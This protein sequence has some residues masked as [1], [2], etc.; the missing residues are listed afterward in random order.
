MPDIGY[1]STLV[2]RL[3]V[4]PGLIIVRVAPD[5]LP[6]RFEAGQYTV[7]GLKRSAPAVVEAGAAAEGSRLSAEGPAGGDEA[8]SAEGGPG[9]A[10]ADQDPG[11]LIRRAYSIASSSKENE[12]LEFYLTLVPSGELTPRLFALETGDRLFLGPKATGLFTLAR[13]PEGF[14][15]V[16]VA[17]GTGLAPHMSILRTEL[18]GGTARRY[19]VLH[20]ARTS[21]DLGYRAELEALARNY[22]NLAYLPAIT[23]PRED[24][25]WAGLTGYLQ[26]L[27]FAPEAERSAG[28]P[29]DPGAAH[30]FL[31][32]NPAMIEAARD[33]LLA[34]GF[35][36]DKGK[37]AGTLH[38]EE[39]W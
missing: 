32:G 3:E 36:R 35:T 15:A 5:Q 16:L 10:V 34:R 24:R 13:V 25:S 1:N 28:F 23:R 38:I 7:L 29:L 37:T 31:C 18:A 22:P 27:L 4:A 12:Y 2:H 6:Y 14:H 11:K 9:N 26:D 20:G 19:L 8:G 21:G 33:R 17:T 39:Y 30:V